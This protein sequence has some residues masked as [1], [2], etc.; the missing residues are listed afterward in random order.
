MARILIAISNSF[1]YGEAYA[2]RVRALSKLFQKSGY[3]VDIL[4]D[5]V[6]G[7]LKTQEY[8]RV[9]AVADSIYKGWRKLLVLP[10]DY[11]KKMEKIM[12]SV[13]YDFIVSQSM[14]DRFKFVLKLSNKYKIPLILDS[15]E[16]YDVRSFRRGKLDIRYF[17]FKRCF[18]KLY[19][20]ANGVITISRLLEEYY[21][22]HIKNTLFSNPLIAIYLLSSLYNGPLPYISR[23]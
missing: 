5:F 18:N 8:G 7:D 16:W 1:P 2:A 13:E 14:F 20:K 19:N 10:H 15:C 22:K 23:I 3:H 6:S 12:T 9:F 11:K 21:K 4:C 17:Q